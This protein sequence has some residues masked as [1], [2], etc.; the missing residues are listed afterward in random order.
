M[1]LEVHASCHDNIITAAG[2]SCTTK[3]SLQSASGMRSG[4]TA[5]ST[6]RAQVE[7][8]LPRPPG[9]DTAQRLDE[10]GH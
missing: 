8:T 10:S 1:N 2:Q 5:R 4:L 7:C 9:R 6:Y 3:Q